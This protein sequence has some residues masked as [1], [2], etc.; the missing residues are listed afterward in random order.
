MQ[1][2]GEILREEREKRGLLLRQ[3]G[4]LMDVDQA[5]ISKFERG[6]RKPTREQVL[7]FAKIFKL[8]ENELMLAWLS[9]KLVSE[10]QHEELGLEALKIAEVKVNHL[11]K[12][13]A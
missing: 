6:E 1:L 13:R 3:V 5:L 11:K 4:A 10:V 8:K 12:K 9:D 2:L 7:A